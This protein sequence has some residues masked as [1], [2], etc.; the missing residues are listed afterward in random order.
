MIE[1]VPIASIR[2]GERRRQE[3]GD[4][5]ALAKNI[6]QHGLI[7]PIVISDDNELIVGGRR[8]QACAKLGWSDID[9]RRWRVL[10]E[11]ERREIELAENLDRKDLTAAERSR[12]I[13]A[14]A[15][16]AAEID[17][18]EFRPNSGR[19][20]RGRPSEPG[21]LRRVSER[22]GQPVQTIH[23]AQQHVAALNTYPELEPKSQ[24]EALEIAA[25]LNDMAPAQREHVRESLIQSG[26]MPTIGE[27]A[28]TLPDS[29]AKAEFE[30][31]RYQRKLGD[32]LRP[33]GTLAAKY[34]P[35]D[36]AAHI[37]EDFFRYHIEIPLRDAAHWADR[38]RAAMPKPL[39]VI[40]GGR[41]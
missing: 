28:A 35:E 22:T 10:E 23:D 18:R 14:L 15:E 30:R 31:A 11:A 16:T 7:H 3:Y 13:V 6:D 17:R 19:N 38:V 20:G 25:S 1:R 26:A 24:A 41:S 9:A 27:V 40:Q 2:I 34:D 32:S 4:I 33:F 39:Q 5:A 37:D 29:P 36:V 12:Q 8:L 21:S